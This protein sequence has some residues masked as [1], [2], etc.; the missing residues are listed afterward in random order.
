[1]RGLIDDVLTG[2][3]LAADADQRFR[4]HLRECE[5]CRARYDQ[6]LGVLRLARGGAEALAP[7]EAERA[8][9]R[10]VR[11]VRPV[12]ATPSPWPWRPLLAGAVAVAAVVTLLLWPRAPV[13]VVLSAGKG[14]TVDGEAAVKDLVLLEGAVLATEKEDSAV[15]LRD[16]KQKRGVLLR[17]STT[18]KVVSVDEVELQAGRVRLQVKDPGEPLL[19]KAEALRVVQDTA[20]VFIVEQR[21][22]GTL[23]AVHQGA[24]VVRA[25]SES[26][27]V[28]EGQEAE[29]TPGGLSKPRPVA[30]SSLIED[31]GDG[32]V[33]SAILRFLRQLLDVIAKALSGD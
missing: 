13:G 26:V 14:F 29:L 30:A 22:T 4:A 21:A 6:A 5:A 27:E 16:G 18:V 32:T 1:V 24:V 8:T 9:S 33:W 28:R 20:G 17:G 2:R 12:E 25:K 7:G 10:A 31:R 15:L 11:L 19:V 23:V 3:V